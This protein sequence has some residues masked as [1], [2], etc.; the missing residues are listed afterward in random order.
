MAKQNLSRRAALR[1]QQELE[2]KQKRTNRIIGIGAGILVVAIVAIIAIVAIPPLLRGNQ[3]V[4]AE[5]LTPPNA[6]EAHGI[7][8]NGTEPTEDTPHVIIYEDYLCPGC[9]GRHLSYGPSIDQLADQ[10]QIT[11]EYRTTYFQDRQGD[12]SARAAMAAAAADEVGHFKEYHSVL[13]QNQS[14]YTQR[15]LREEF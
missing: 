6:T 2:Q 10:G 1:Q 11:V 5:Q 8:L 7:L 12:A 15:Q 9:A 14:Q 3:E 4:T 13:F